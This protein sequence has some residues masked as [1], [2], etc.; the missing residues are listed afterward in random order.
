MPPLSADELRARIERDLPG[1]LQTPETLQI[2]AVRLPDVARYLRDEL[3]YTFLTNLTAV[4]YLAAG[5]IEVV[6]H[7]ASLAGGAPLAVRVRIPRDD[8]R[9]PS[10]A[11]LWPGAE[12]QEREAYDLFGVWF[13]GHRDLRRVYMWD[14]FEGFPMR[15][16][17][18]RQGDKYFAGSGEE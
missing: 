17:F 11:P 5:A 6:Y 15:K 1:A 12:L 16:D 14:A 8:A 13:E 4:D 10:L 9:I 3:G 18:P 7:F 2:A